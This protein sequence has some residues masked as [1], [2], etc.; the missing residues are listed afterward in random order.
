MLPH[1]CSSW[2][3]AGQN[4]SVGL[5][6]E[7]VVQEKQHVLHAISGGISAAVGVIQLTVLLEQ[8]FQHK[9]E[10]L[11]PELSV[12]AISLTRF[13]YVSS[14]ST[15]LAKHVR[16]DKCLERG[17]YNKEAA[18][19]ISALKGFWRVQEDSHF[20]H[21]KL[22]LK[23]MVSLMTIAFIWNKTRLSRLCFSPVKWC[24][25]PNVD[26]YQ[27]TAL[28]CCDPADKSPLHE[29]FLSPRHLSL[30][31]WRPAPLLPL[32]LASG[33]LL[34]LSIAAVALADSPSVSNSVKSATHEILPLQV[35]PHCILASS[36]STKCGRKR[37]CDQ[38][39][40]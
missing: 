19:K 20:A 24:S 13:Q 10:H 31:Y 11:Q 6:R 22:S 30:H 12:Q 14:A 37:H 8:H 39:T 29:L 26:Q 35:S 25:P 4:A 34:G 33:L 23:T 17:E 36:I 5:V 18:S 27:C 9:G 38:L 7:V 3:K 2:Q 40:R 32:L 1:P 15:I 16:D 21:A 28:A